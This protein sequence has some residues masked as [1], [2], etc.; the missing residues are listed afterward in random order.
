MKNFFVKESRKLC[1]GLGG[2]ALMV[3]LNLAVGGQIFLLPAYLAGYFLAAAYLT[4][5]GFRLRRTVGKDKAS[6]KREM[7]IGMLLRLVMLFAVL[8]AALKISFNVFMTVIAGF[9]VF[10]VLFLAHLIIAVFRL[11]ILSEDEAEDPSALS[12]AKEV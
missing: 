12:M 7:L 10:Y 11:N 2:A 4:V 9:G 1:I 8:G 6:A 5:A 3:A